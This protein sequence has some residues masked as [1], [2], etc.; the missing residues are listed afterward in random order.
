MRARGYGR[1]INIS[2]VAGWVATPFNGAYASSKFALEAQTEALRMELWPFGVTVSSIQPGLFDTDFQIN[3]IVHESF[4]DIDV[5]FF[6]FIF[7]LNN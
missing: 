2:S 4:N 5:Y 3:M 1:I 6:C 7:I